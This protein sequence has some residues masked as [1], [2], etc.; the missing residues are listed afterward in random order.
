[1][2]GGI[3]IYLNNELQDY[4]ILP[5]DNYVLLQ[6]VDHHRFAILSQIMD[7]TKRACELT[8]EQAREFTQELLDLKI[9]HAKDANALGILI[10]LLGIVHDAIINNKRLKFFSTSLIG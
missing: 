5:N 4:E 3:D 8:R 9:L 1:M 6:G 10:D 2:I 7:P